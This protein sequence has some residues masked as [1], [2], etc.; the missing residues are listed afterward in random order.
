LGD[1]KLSVA[2]KH[3]QKDWQNGWA[4]NLKEDSL[5]PHYFDKFDI[6]RLDRKFVKSLTP[7]C[8][9]KM[10]YE[11]VD[12][13][14]KKYFKGLDD[15]YEFG[16]GTGH[17][18]MR[19]AQVNARAQLHGSD[20]V[21]A[22]VDLVRSRGNDAFLFDFFNPDQG[23]KLEPNSGVYTVAALEQ[24]GTNFKKFINY[25]IKQKPKVVVHIEPIMELFD[26]KN[27]MDSLVIKYCKKRKYLSG[28]LIYL[29]KLEKEGK[30][31]IH[32]AKRNGVGSLFIEGYSVV[33]WSPK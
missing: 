22:S 2:G 18:L 5:K 7:H 27:F 11:I 13:V 12:K 3:R 26:P 16:C 20:W 24:T 19:L 25:L 32:E 29:R 23:K 21:K 10:L 14:F 6:F 9:K 17:N 15:A 30:I 1:K 8:E 33:A 28:L 31:K 4:E